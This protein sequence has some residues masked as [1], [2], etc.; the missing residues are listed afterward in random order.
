MSQHNADIF[1]KVARQYAEANFDDESDSPLIDELLKGVAVGARILDI[2]CGPGQ[3]SRY[4]SV[5]GYAVDG[6]DLAPEMIKLATKT[7]PEATFAVMD[8]RTL[9]FP[10][11][12]FERILAA[13]ALIF[14]SSD[15][16]VPTLREF[17]RVLKPGG[18]IGL[19][20][21]VGEPDHLDHNPLKPDEIMKV[22]FFTPELLR[23]QLEQVS[24]KVYFQDVVPNTDT[25]SHSKG[26][27]ATLAQKI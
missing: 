2:G 10:E 7:A 16:V 15:E 20:N 23:N 6:I 4:M 12:T 1:N 8:M 19:V 27:I 24:L 9:A 14:V 11:A 3:F 25:Q 26:M 13:F 17:A 5:R 18:K 22:N 21:Q